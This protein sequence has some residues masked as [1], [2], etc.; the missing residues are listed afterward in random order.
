MNPLMFLR[1]VP[2][3]EGLSLDDLLSV[4]EAL[5]REEYLANE[6]VVRQ[7]EPGVTLFIVARGS[8]S[9]LLESR[10]GSAPREVAQLR[11]GEYFGEMSLFDDVPRSATVVTLTD[12]VFL[13]L[14]R[15]RFSILV[16]QRPVV[17]MRICRMFGSR[18]RETNRRLL[19]AQGILTP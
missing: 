6:I 10:D 16:M 13:S 19:A 14:D 4:D 8:A 11:E 7:G 12:A 3:F 1:T 18:L 9:V 5:K 17:L 2:L 15:D